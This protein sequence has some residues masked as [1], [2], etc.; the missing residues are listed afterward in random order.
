MRAS[1]AFFVGIATVG[2]A[3]TGG[4]GGGLLIGNFMSPSAKHTAEAARLQPAGSPKTASLRPASTQPMPVAGAVSYAAAT[5]AFT[6]PSVD[7]R[8]PADRRADN[9]AAPHS[10][11]PAAAPRE[12]TAKPPENVAP[13]APAQEAQQAPSAKQAGAPEDAYAR[14]RDSDLKRAADK[15][16]AER[17]LR[18]SE[19]NRHEAAQDQ[20]Q[21]QDQN[22]DQQAGDDRGRGHD[23]RSADRANRS[24]NYSYNH[25][26]RRYYRDDS[27]GQYRDAER[28]DDDRG[29][30]YYLDEGPRVDAGP[31]FGFPPIQ[32]FGPDD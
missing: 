19:R 1:T 25:F 10:S 21:A 17:V 32:L 14:A 22:S 23:D 6:N 18:F 20:S 2:L 7:G 28:D 13:R 24:S 4:L 31:R 11:V 30:G 9:G 3:I 15:R 26:D 16:R 8:A 27:R 29:P 5:L 12:Q